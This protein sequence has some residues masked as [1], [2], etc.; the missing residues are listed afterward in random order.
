M[1]LLRWDT[2]IA[3]SLVVNDFFFND[4]ATT[5]IYTL[6]LHDALPI[7]YQPAG[8]PAD[9][10]AAAVHDL[11]RNQDVPDVPGVHHRDDRPGHVVDRGD[12]DVTRVQHD[13]V[14][15]LAR[16]QRADL[17]EHAVRRRTRDRHHLD[18]LPAGNH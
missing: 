2:G 9:Q 7:S 10:L 5:E 17:V 15:L 6:S 3:F 14:G 13:D 11:T 1:W 12:V 18:D 8:V 16:R 4:T